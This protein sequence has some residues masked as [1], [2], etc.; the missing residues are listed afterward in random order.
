VLSVTLP[1]KKGSFQVLNNHAALISTLEA[2]TLKYRTTKGEVSLEV[3]GGV[4]EVL[5]NN[6]Q[7]LIE[8]LKK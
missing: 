2:G 1:G 7:V 5:N 8:G 6:I 3:L 4:A